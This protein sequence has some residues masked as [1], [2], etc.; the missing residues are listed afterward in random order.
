MPSGSSIHI[1][2]KPQGSVAGS[3]MMRTPAAASRACSAWTFRTWI[4]IITERPGGPA[5][6]PETSSNPWPRKKPLRDLLEGRTPGRRPGPGRRGRSGGCGPGR[7]GAGGSGCSE[8]P[9][10]YFSITL[11]EEGV[12]GE[13]AQCRLRAA[14][15]LAAMPGHRRTERRVM[16]PCGRGDCGNRCGADQA[17]D[18]AQLARRHARGLPGDGR[19]GD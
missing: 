5:A 4:Q 8:C 2:I 6:C 14:Y 10:D 9:R 13:R 3:R 16:R 11:S 12:Q 1:S 17:V 15:R 7:W 19:R 18:G